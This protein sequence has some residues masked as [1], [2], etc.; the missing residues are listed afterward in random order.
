MFDIGATGDFLL[1]DTIKLGALMVMLSMLI[2]IVLRIKSNPLHFL[3][4]RKRMIADLIYVAFLIVVSIFFR[5]EGN[6]FIYF[7]F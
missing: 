1:N 5:G 2:E 6:E 7:Q 4:G 3:K